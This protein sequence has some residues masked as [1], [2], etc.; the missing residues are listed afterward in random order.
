M[1][2]TILVVDDD[3]AVRKVLTTRLQLSGYTVLTAAHGAEALEL[4]DRHAPDL[5]LL[6]LQ[7]PVLDG[8]GFVRAFHARGGTTPIV[9]MSA[10][11]EV[12]AAAQELG[13]EDALPKPMAMAALSSTV[14]LWTRP[15]PSGP[16]DEPA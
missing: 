14:S 12:A 2:G 10:A 9:V 11:Q 16:A 15:H 6:D 13:V 5:I 4:L 7:M 1:P 3:P 8:W